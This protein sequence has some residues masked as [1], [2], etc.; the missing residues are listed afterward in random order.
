MYNFEEL[1]SLKINTEIDGA[2]R[3]FEWSQFLA[4]F[5]A[6]YGGQGLSHGNNKCGIIT[7]LPRNMEQNNIQMVSDRQTYIMCDP[8]MNVTTNSGWCPTADTLINFAELP[9]STIRVPLG[10]IFSLF[11]L[12]THRLL[13]GP[14][15][16]AACAAQWNSFDCKGNKTQ[17]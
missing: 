5:K 16:K 9:C 3:R 8:R 10:L 1:R 17:H 14:V 15:R 13:C 6:D 12:R 2:R 4:S 11:S 7:N